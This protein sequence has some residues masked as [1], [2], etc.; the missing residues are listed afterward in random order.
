MSA[1]SPTNENREVT[2]AAATPKHIAIVM[3]GNGRWAVK[4]RSPRFN[5][6]RA[7]VNTLRDMVQHCAKRGVE[8]LTLFAFS[9]ENWRRPAEEVGL[10]MNLFV[11]ALQ[12]EMRKLHEN[13]IRLRV[14]GARTAF[15]EHL[16][17]QISYP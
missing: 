15:N 2:S 5:G 12:Q 17:T 10:L 9:S 6:H 11:S 1:V 16:Q 4:R 3:D 7:G 13:N 8:A 14:A